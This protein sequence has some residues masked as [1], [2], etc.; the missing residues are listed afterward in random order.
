MKASDLGER[1]IIELIWSVIR[2][3]AGSRAVDSM[4]LPPP[5][6]ASALRMADGTFLVLKT[7]AFAKK[8]DAPKGMRHY[9]MGWKAVTMNISDLAAKGARPEAFMFSLSIPRRYSGSLIRSL[10]SGISDASNEYRA[11]VLGGDVGEAGELIVAGFAVGIAKNLVKRSGA[12]PG[13]ILAV[14]GPFGDTA[15]AFKILLEGADSPPPLRR[16]LCRSVYRPRAR[17][18]VGAALADSCA[19][20]SCMD[21][22]DG[23]AFTLNELAKSSGVGFVLSVLPVSDL[24]KEFAALQKV[25]AWDLALFGG[26]EYEL[27]FTVKPGLWDRAVGAA[28][29]AGCEI[30]R[31]GEAVSG[32]K[33]VLADGSGEREIPHKGWEHLR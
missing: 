19:L 8:T 29:A 22:S 23:L 27:V 33:V 20:T 16:A 26:E 10:V 17:A 2:A 3:K 15:S 13:D 12:K 30:I 14:T 18:K 4:A 31:I 32:S 21:S 5:D 6:D 24:A 1:G 11:P 9:Q 28:R 25:Q 7:D